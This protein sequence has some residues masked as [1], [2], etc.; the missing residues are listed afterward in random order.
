MRSRKVDTHGGWLELDEGSK[1]LPPEV[2]E[3]RLEAEL[4]RRRDAAQLANGTEIDAHRAASSSPEI[5]VR[6][7]TASE[8]RRIEKGKGEGLI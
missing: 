6:A 7:S 3:A 8:S 1:A 5:R 4:R 2:E